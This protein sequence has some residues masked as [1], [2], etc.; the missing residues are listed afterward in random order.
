MQRPEG[1]ELPRETTGITRWLVTVAPRATKSPRWD[2]KADV[3]AGRGGAG[4]DWEGPSVTKLTHSSPSLAVISPASSQ[5]ATS[6]ARCSSSHGAVEA[7]CSD[8]WGT[9]PSLYPHIIA[10]SG[11][12]DSSGYLPPYLPHC[13]TASLPYQPLWYELCRPDPCRSAPLSAPGPS[14]LSIPA[15]D[16]IAANPYGAST[17]D[18]LSFLT[19]GGGSR[20]SPPL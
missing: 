2:L 15:N 18:P 20:L 3:W 11:A 7:S 13:L 17:P 4:R 6:K 9:P 8:S 14:A 5:S 10:H 16:M 19:N 12:W 1:P